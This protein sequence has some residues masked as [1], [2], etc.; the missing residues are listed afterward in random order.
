M[1]DNARITEQEQEEFWASSAWMPRGTRLRAARSM[2]WRLESLLFRSKDP[3][4]TNSFL[5]APP[6]SS[7][8]AR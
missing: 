6:V 8:I 4:L 1:N 3:S 2:G 5:A 7:K